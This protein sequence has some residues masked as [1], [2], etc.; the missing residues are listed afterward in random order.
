MSDVHRAGQSVRHYWL[1]LWRHRELFEVLDWRDL[2][3]YKQTVVGVLRARVT[4]ADHACS[5]GD[6]GGVAKTAI[7]Q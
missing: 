5:Y 1:D 3:V 6:F 2:S 7:G 4:I